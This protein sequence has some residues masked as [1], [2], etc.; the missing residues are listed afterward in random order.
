MRIEFEIDAPR[1]EVWRAIAEPEGLLGWFATDARVTPEVGGEYY[2]AH[3]EYGQGSTIEHIVPGER[4]RTASGETTTEFVLE[5]HEGKTL[6][7]IVQSGFGGD[8]YESLERGWGQYVQTLRHYLGRHRDEPA[9]GAYVYVKSARSRR[10]APRCRSRCP[11]VLTCSTRR[12]GASARASRSSATGCIA[13]PFKAVTERPRSGCTSS[14]TERGAIASTTCVP[15]WSAHSAWRCGS[16]EAMALGASLTRSGEGGL[17]SRW[18]VQRAPVPARKLEP[19]A[20]S[21]PGRAP[22]YPP[23]APPVAQWIEQRFLGR[24]SGQKSG[25]SSSA[26]NGPQ[27]HQK[28]RFRRLR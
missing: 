7:R 18:R 26:V 22:R 21:N 28:R 1:E 8:D 3:G 12:R 20:C 4:L 10:R 25:K 23:R 17:G 2:V 24:T 5:G 14:P 15:T 27:R 13:R 6:L 19:R 9:A 11:T 16:S